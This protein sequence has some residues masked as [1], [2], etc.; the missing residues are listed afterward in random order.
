VLRDREPVA[1]RRESLLDE[2][3]GPRR[4][5]EGLL[6]E[7]CCDRA[8]PREQ[9]LLML[10]RVALGL[11]DRTEVGDDEPFRPP[12]EDPAAALHHQVNVDVR[13][14]SDGDGDTGIRGLFT[15]HVPGEGEAGLLIEVGHVMPGVSRGVRNPNVA[16]PQRQPLPAR[17]RVNPVAGNR[18]DLAPEA[19]HVVAIQTRR[20]VEQ[21]FGIREVRCPPLVDHDEQPRKVSSQRAGRPGVVQVNVGEQ[22]GPDVIQTGSERR[23]G[24]A[25]PFERGGRPG[26]HH[27]QALSRLEQ[28]GGDLPG[29]AQVLEV[30][31]RA[32]GRNRLHRCKI[33]CPA[34][35]TRVRLQAMRTPARLLPFGLA[36]TLVA[37]TPA[38]AQTVAWDSLSNAGIARASG[39]VDSVFVDRLVA[40]HVVRGGDWVSYL[41]ARLGAVPIPDSSGIRVAVDS[42]RIR[43]RG[44]VVDLP[45]ET[46]RLFGGLL[47]FMDSTTMLEAEVVMA[48]TGPGVIRFVLTTI[49]FNDIT[50]P[51]S[52]LQRFLAQVGR[53]YPVLTETGRE[54]LVAIPVDGRVAL[55][56]NGVRVWIAPAAGSP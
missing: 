48:P 10:G 50:I 43:I 49:R 23:D 9:A 51:E 14:G 21:P 35:R 26:I 38:V 24:L 31:Q 12:F 41:A 36:L 33:A 6:F 18:E 40:E 56:P 13:R 37:A 3:A 29:S 2:A 55:V 17:E 5:V 20:T 4:V 52:I 19:I 25:E 7:P 46:H 44:R 54:L 28:A 8:R 53:Q 16:T 47:F 42:A 1:E 39:Q 11:A 27:H 15:E 30:D 32:T 22:K 45:P 34:G